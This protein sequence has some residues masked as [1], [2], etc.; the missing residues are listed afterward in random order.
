MKRDTV[1][2]PDFCRALI[3][4]ARWLT[5]AKV[6]VGTG[7]PFHFHGPGF[8]EVI[9]GAKRWFLYPFEERPEFDPDRT[10]LEW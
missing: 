8:A 6:F 5:V 1:D 10:T 3:G 7:V 9:H 2:L 4:D